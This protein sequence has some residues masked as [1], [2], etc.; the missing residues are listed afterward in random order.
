MAN[1]NYILLDSSNSIEIVNL[2]EVNQVWIRK[3][4]DEEVA[5][6]CFKDGGSHIVPPS[7]VD[8][9]QDCL[10]E[11]PDFFKFTAPNSVAGY[12]R[13]YVSLKNFTFMEFFVDDPWRRFD[14]KEVTDFYKKL[15]FLKK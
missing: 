2:D 10:D 8:K 5:E 7:I 9:L 6:I 15:V 3:E 11:S 14:K 1:E 4:K 12:R 13:L